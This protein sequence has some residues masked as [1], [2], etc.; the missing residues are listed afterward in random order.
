MTRVVTNEVTFIGDSAKTEGF[1]F[2]I[3][4]AK[5]AEI[6]LYIQNDINGEEVFINIFF[7]EL[8]KIM[9][10]IYF[11][12]DIVDIINAENPAFFID[13]EDDELELLGVGV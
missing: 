4:G 1:T 5:S 2:E 7:D 13:D 11:D 8:F 9:S 12:T 6:R 3:L 10:N